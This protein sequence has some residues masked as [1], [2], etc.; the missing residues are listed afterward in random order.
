MRTGAVIAALS[1]LATAACGSASSGTLLVY[2]S[3]TQ[4]TVDAVVAGF[5]QSSGL[6]V[7]VFRAPTGELNAR[8]SSELA[9]GPMAAN[10]LWLTDPLSMYSYA[11]QDLLERWTPDEAEVLAPSLRTDT[12]FATR[13]LYMVVVTSGNTLITTWDDLAQPGLR[14]AIPDPGFAGSALATLGYF[15]L[16]PSFGFDYY[17]RLHANGAV[18]ISSP[19]D[20]VAGVAEGNFDA[21]ITLDFLARG[22][23]DGGSPIT[24]V[25][26]SPGAITI[27]SPIA[28]VA[29]SVDGGAARRFVEF[30][31]SESGQ[32]LIASTGWAPARPGVVGPPTPP[33][34]DAVLPDWPA[35]AEIQDEL[36]E[37]YR[38]LF[39]G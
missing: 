35:L 14:V 5:T 4:A 24:R 29:D 1:L 9:T 37:R 3:V 27:Y 34:A 38:D 8:I 2:T 15:A 32:E 28:V 11:D 22:A 19:G 6:E 26:P 30:V 21:G 13:M 16:D 36:L 23:M 10:I 7:D 31:L 33:G 39:E 12:F 20:V 25:W 17:E 18:Q